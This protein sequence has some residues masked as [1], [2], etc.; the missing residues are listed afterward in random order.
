MCMAHFPPC[1]LH[2]WGIETNYYCTLCTKSGSDF[3]PLLYLPQWPD[4][5]STTIAVSAVCSILFWLVMTVD[6]L[7]LRQGGVV[8][9]IVV[10]QYSSTPTTKL[11]CNKLFSLCDWFLL[12]PVCRLLIIINQLYRIY[13]MDFPVL[14]GY[15]ILITYVNLLGL[16][17]ICFMCKD[18]AN[19]TEKYVVMY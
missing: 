10:C 19:L 4:A 6:W 1:T 5:W 3:R 12:L 17:L 2:T 9:V 18:L 16:Q 14:M 13:V 11:S 8:V 7:Y 15:C